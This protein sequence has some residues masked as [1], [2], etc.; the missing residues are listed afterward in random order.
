MTSQCCVHNLFQLSV[1]AGLSKVIIFTQW[2]YFATQE[3]IKS[4]RDDIRRVL[5]EFFLINRRLTLTKL[6]KV[7]AIVDAHLPYTG[8]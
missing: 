4:W 8:Y 7:T 1:I 6:L 2:P 3:R 5:L